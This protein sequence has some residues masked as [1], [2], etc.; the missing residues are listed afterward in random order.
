M[1]A[2][3]TEAAVAHIYKHR[4]SDEQMADMAMR[5]HPRY[6]ML[7]KPEGFTGDGFY[8]AMDYGDPQGI[9][10]DFATAQAN[11]ASSKG[12]QLFMT[13]RQKYMVC[14]I[15]GI[16]MLKA[17]DSVGAFR[18]LVT[19][20]SD[21]AIRGLG[22][23][24]AFDAY[25]T[26]NGMRG[27]V[28]S[29]NGNILTLYTADDVR[30]FYVGMTLIGDD[31]ITGAS[32]NV[33]TCTVTKISRPAGTITVSTV[34]S[35]NII[36]D[37]Y[38]FR[39]GDPGTCIDG[40]ALHIP[41][42]APSSGES[43]RGIDRSDEEQLLSGFRLDDS[44]TPLEENIALCLV[45]TRTYSS[46]GSE[47]VCYANPLKVFDVVRRGNGT[48]ERDNA[49]GTLTWGFDSVNVI[50]NY[51]R[52]KLISD[53]DCPP[54]RAYICSPADEE[55]RRIDEITHIIR[56]DGK[57]SLRLAAADGIEIRGRSVSNYAIRRPGA[58]AVM[59]VA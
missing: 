50:T 29:I 5:D 52:C 16:A 32:P 58:F 59:S 26:G 3:S 37:N 11:A 1:A 42:T 17:R 7:D 13:T 55:L 49:G 45:N 46:A 19:D 44:A 21:K 14:T 39:Q 27:R 48:V 40:I 51:G 2:A 33:G 57:P 23:N 8:Y 53:P 38:L 54:D 25:R 24:L 10:G 12:K 4:Y 36:A 43:F 41:L 15:D 56:D 31:V 30:N 22:A 34:A 20:E 6:A 35:A 28:R 47:Q 18:K 9:S